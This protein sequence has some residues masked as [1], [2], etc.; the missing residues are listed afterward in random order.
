MK[1]DSGSWIILC[2]S[3]LCA[4]IAIFFG[5]EYPLIGIVTILYGVGFAIANEIGAL[6][7]EI[8]K[9]E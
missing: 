3:A 5:K 4:G 8:K 9:K 2:I 7:R 6:R 1:L